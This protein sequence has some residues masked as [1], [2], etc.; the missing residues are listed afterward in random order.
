[1]QIKPRLLVSV[2]GAASG[3]KQATAKVRKKFKRVK[4][5]KHK[6]MSRALLH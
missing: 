1:M 2:V 4:L 5:T 6:D 3:W